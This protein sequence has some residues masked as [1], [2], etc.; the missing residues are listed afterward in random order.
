MLLPFAISGYQVQEEE[1]TFYLYNNEVSN[2]QL[3]KDNLCELDPSKELRFVVHGRG[4]NHN[5]SFVVEATEAYLGTGD[6][7][8]I[9][10][11]WSRLG[12]QPNYIPRDG[13]ADAGLCIHLTNTNQNKSE[14]FQVISLQN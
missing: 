5:I 12:A 6:F 10:V 3:T 13:S 7:N 1:I 14:W 2:L 11:D 9:Q 4:G 8:V